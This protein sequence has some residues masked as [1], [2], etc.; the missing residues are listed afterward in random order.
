MQ[1]NINTIITNSLDINKENL[2]INIKEILKLLK[3]SILSNKDLILD[4]NKIDSK[5]N[6][7]FIM[8]FNIVNNIF[9]NLE[10]ETILFGTTIVSKR[11]DKMKLIYGQEVLEQGNVIVIND[12][13]PYIIIELAIRNILAGNTTIFSNTGYM[14]GTNQL[15]I[16]LIQDTLEKL[17][18]SKYLLQLF[19]TEEFNTILSNFANIDLVICIGNNTLQRLVLNKSKNKTLISGYENFDLYI[20]DTN[21]L[22]LLNSIINSNPNIQ[23]YINKNINIDYKNAILVDD[24]EEAIAQ[25]N[26]NGSKYSSAIFTTSKE[27]ASK[28]IKEVKSKTITINT[29]PTIERVIDIKQ[30]DLVIIKNVIYPLTYTF[31]STINID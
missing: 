13:N 14:Y 15:I 3:E 26:Y 9:S 10:K 23:L 25:I 31:T 6:N 28:F 21:H 5:N 30:E 8:D 20:E 22:D 11:N 24:L 16:K 7:G 27:N 2:R 12:G 17:N 29:S 19:I 18:I 4:T 1:D